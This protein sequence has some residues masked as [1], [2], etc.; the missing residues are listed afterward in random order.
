MSGNGHRH[1][2]TSASAPRQGGKAGREIIRDRI[3]RRMFRLM[4]KL[5]ADLLDEYEEFGRQT[6]TRVRVEK[7]NEFLRLVG[8][9]SKPSREFG[10]D[11]VPATLTIQTPQGLELGWINE[12]EPG[13]TLLHGEDQ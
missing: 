7:P 11:R 1:R 6:I 10:D 8:D 13:R 2:F 3:V 5:G 4:D 9:Y 12:P